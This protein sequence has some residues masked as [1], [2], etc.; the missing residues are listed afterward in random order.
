[1]LMEILYFISLV[2]S[3]G[4]TF[5]KGLKAIWKRIKIDIQIEIR[6]KKK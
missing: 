6:F 5:F 3:L 1:M 4:F 2:S